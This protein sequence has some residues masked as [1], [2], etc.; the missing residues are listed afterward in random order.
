MALTSDK[1][2]QN[3][4]RVR[5]KRLTEAYID[6]GQDPDTAARL[7]RQKVRE[8]L[9]KDESSNKTVVLGPDGQTTKTYGDKEAREAIRDP[10]VPESIKEQL[11]AFI[12]PE[13]KSTAPSWISTRLGR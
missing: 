6:D 11:R 1:I 8:D 2:Q 3:V 5:V 10:D 9:Y 4:Y 13:K 12:G 7:A